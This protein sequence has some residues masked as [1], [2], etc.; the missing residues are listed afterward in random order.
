MHNIAI[1]T[2]RLEI[3]DEESTYAAAESNYSLVRRGP[4][5]ETLNEDTIEQALLAATIAWLVNES[6]EYGALELLEATVVIE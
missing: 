5:S 6:G 2:L 4:L 3:K 1:I